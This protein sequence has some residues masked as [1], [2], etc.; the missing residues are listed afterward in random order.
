M[1]RRYTQLEE[2]FR[3]LPPEAQRQMLAF[4]AFLE[5]RYRVP[6]ARPAR[7]KKPLRAYAFVGLWREREEFEDSR[8]WVRNLRRQEWE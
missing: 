8:R 6:Q 3:A 4:L 5:Q 2:R 7:S 1:S